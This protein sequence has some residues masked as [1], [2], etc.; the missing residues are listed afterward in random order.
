MSN[1]AFNIDIVRFDIKA[2]FRGSTYR[3]GE[4]DQGPTL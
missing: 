3:H 4:F 1:H 2:Q